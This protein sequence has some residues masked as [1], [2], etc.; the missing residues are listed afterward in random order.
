M[1]APGFGS[2]GSGFGGS[3]VVP[4]AWVHVGPSEPTLAEPRT[5]EP[6]TLGTEPPAP[7]TPMN[8]R[9]Y[10]HRIAISD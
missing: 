7:P 5:L 4:R 1:G 8:P 6:S 3:R 2:E 9:T 10:K